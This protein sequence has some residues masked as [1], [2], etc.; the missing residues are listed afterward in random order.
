MDRRVG[1]LIVIHQDQFH[2][3]AFLREELLIQF[4][5]GTGCSEY[6]GGV[7]RLRHPE[8]QDVPVLAVQRCSGNP[9][10]AVEAVAPLV[11][12]PGRGPVFADAIEELTDLLPESPRGQGECEVL[13]PVDGRR[14]VLAVAGEQLLDDQ[15]LLGT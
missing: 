10:R 15:V 12:L 7:E 5:E 11:E 3:L 1:F 2:A 9:V 14:A 4:Q 6:S 8:V 13:R